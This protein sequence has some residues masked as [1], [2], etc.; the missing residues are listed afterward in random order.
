MENGRAMITAALMM[1]VLILP[2]IITTA[3]DALSTVPD[4]LRE[5]A[6][7]WA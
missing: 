2:T 5:A 6:K 4:T 7:G 1:A 3:E